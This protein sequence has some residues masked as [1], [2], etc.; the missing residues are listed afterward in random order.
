MQSIEVVIDVG[1]L[2]SLHLRFNGGRIMA[3]AQ[4]AVSSS[5]ADESGAP[6]TEKGCIF[7]LMARRTMSAAQVAV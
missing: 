6:A 5:V 7:A 3:A 4:V 2:G 1:S